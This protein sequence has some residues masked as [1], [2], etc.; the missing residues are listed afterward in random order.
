[1]ISVALNFTI[2]IGRDAKISG[3]ASTKSQPIK[4]FIDHVE[5]QIRPAGTGD[6]NSGASQEIR[7]GLDTR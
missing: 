5:I 3:I 1:M 2:I 4:R 6:I 7:D